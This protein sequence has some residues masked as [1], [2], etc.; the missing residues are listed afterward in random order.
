[1]QAYDSTNI[2]AKILRKE[3][4]ATVIHETACSLAF[5]DAFPKAPLHAL[6]IPKGAYTDLHDFCKNASDTE[7]TDFWH[8][9]DH[10]IT[11][12]NL[13]ESGCRLISN[14]GANGGQEVPHFHVH[15]C[16]GTK[17]GPMLVK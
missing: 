11:D 17:L 15:I 10:V 7:I 9:V 14:S 8:A 2:F 12:L 6:V 4:P 1:M 16:G 5:H 3:I 13:V